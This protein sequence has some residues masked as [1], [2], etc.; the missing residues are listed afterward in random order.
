[1]DDLSFEQLHKIEKEHT[2][3]KGPDFFFPQLYDIS[4]TNDH[5]Q[6]DLAKFGYRKK[7]ESN[8]LL[9]TLLYF[10]YLLEPA[11]TEIWQLDFLFSNLAYLCHSF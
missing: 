8:S 5:L 11:V 1:M 7:C 4:Q 6:E 2:C 10:G 9:R 3:P